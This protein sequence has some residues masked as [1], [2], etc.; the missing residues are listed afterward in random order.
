MWRPLATVS[1]TG[2]DFSAFCLIASKASH[3]SSLLNGFLNKF[4]PLCL[5]VCS[6]GSW[7]MILTRPQMPATAAAAPAPDDALF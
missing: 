6:R 5:S 4:Q 3:W 1:V 7:G 2:S